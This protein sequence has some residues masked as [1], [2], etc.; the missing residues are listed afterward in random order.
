MHDHDL[1]DT[2][3]VVQT[4]VSLLFFQQQLLYSKY[5]TVNQ[6]QPDVGIK[7]EDVIE[8]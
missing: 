8:A 6:K 7:K 5:L 4:Q 1:L 2:E 3:A